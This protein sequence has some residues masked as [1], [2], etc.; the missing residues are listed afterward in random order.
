MQ[1]A[2]AASPLSL[3]PHILL[4]LLSLSLLPHPAAAVSPLSLCSH[5]LLLLPSLSLL[6]AEGRGEERRGEERRGE[7]RGP[8]PLAP[9]LRP[10]VL[11]PTQ[12]SGG[13]EKERE[14]TSKQNRTS[15]AEDA[16][17]TGTCLKPAMQRAELSPR[18]AMTASRAQGQ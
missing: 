5:I 7:R 14:M 11:R 4:L 2:A 8:K 13:S 17:L 16:V 3:C 18:H 15:F 9:N 12:C 10:Q 1:P 6:P